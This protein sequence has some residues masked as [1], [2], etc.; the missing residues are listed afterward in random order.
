MTLERCNCGC[1]C[2]SC[3]TRHPFGGGPAVLK[4]QYYEDRTLNTF[5]SSVATLNSL[6]T[7]YPDCDVTWT[8][9]PI[10]RYSETD[11]VWKIR[12]EDNATI[13]IPSLMGL[14][15]NAAFR[16]VWTYYGDSGPAG[17]PSGMPS[18]WKRGWWVQ[19]SGTWYRLNTIY[20]AGQTD[21]DVAWDTAGYR[22]EGLNGTTNGA[23]LLLSYLFQV[24]SLWSD[25]PSYY[26]YTLN[27][28]FSEINNSHISGLPPDW[29]WWIND[30][31]RVVSTGDTA[32]ITTT[33][34]TC[35]QFWAGNQVFS[36]TAT[37]EDGSGLSITRLL[38][39]YRYHRGIY[40]SDVSSAGEVK[41]TSPSR[42]AYNWRE[43]PAIATALTN[44]SLTG[45]YEQYFN[46]I[47]TAYWTDTLQGRPPD[48]YLNRPTTSNDGREFSMEAFP[49]RPKS[50]PFYGTDVQVA[51]IPRA[52]DLVPSWTGPG[53]SSATPTPADWARVG[54]SSGPTLRDW[55]VLIQHSPFV[56]RY[57]GTVAIGGQFRPA[58]VVITP[59]TAADVTIG[60]STG[61]GGGA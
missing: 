15:S 38:Y 9:G 18:R 53:V 26:W 37:A 3:R 52:N 31:W 54:T 59:S 20:D 1:I 34:N 4:W 22:C 32:M 58:E 46:Y 41:N 57:K 6:L 28:R 27:V 39:P 49:L 7:T 30:M 10:L 48:S 8:D 42:R 23:S 36:E 56:A 25:G 50:K 14:Y 60:P 47:N 45:T 17:V 24:S 51:S 21:W 35:Q 5:A 44:S 16:L 40:N 19:S 55:E 29:R 33:C 61:P 11:C 43:N 13:T 2:P 12:P